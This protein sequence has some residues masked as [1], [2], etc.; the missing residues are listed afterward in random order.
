MSVRTSQLCDFP[1]VVDGL[2]PDPA[3]GTCSL[4]QRDACSDHLGAAQFGSIVGGRS[5][6][7]N[8]F[9]G[10]GAAVACVCKLCFD[11]L[12]RLRDDP[13]LLAVAE[14]IEHDAIETARALIAERKLKESAGGTR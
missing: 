14:K 8:Q 10:L 12:T 3:A 9:F 4:C 13:G 1:A 5:H 11:E 7:S 6:P 2:C